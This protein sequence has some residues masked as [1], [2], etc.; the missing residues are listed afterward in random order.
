MFVH[1]SKAFLFSGFVFDQHMQKGLI[2][3]LCTKLQ[4]CRC[5]SAPTGGQQGPGRWPGGT[6]DDR[7]TT[8]QPRAQSS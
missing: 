5:P 8:K 1:S 4:G 7:T 6:R 2:V 3:F